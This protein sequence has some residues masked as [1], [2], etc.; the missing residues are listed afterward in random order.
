MLDGRFDAPLLD[1]LDKAQD[2][3]R[4][5]TL[6]MQRLYDERSKLAWQVAGF[7]I[8]GWLLEHF[9]DAV[10]RMA[11]GGMP[12]E[13]ARMLLRVMPGGEQA[14]ALPGRY[15]RLLRV[16]DFVA[17]MT[18]RYAVDTCLRLRGLGG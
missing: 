2:F 3:R 7:E 11:E 10:E 6:A 18:D 4:F 5:R 14:T 13:R 15:L 8:I 9:C 17:G 16:T 12:S 1:H